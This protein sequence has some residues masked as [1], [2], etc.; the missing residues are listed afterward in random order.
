M[1]EQSFGPDLP[2]TREMFVTVLGRL[3]EAGGVAAAGDPSGF[4]DAAADSY[5]ARYV[6]WASENDIVQGMGSDHFG[7]GAPVT[8]EQMIV[9]VYRYFLFQNLIK[10]AG[11]GELEGYQDTNNVS[12]WAADAFGWAVGQGLITGRSSDLLDPSGQSSRAEVAMF[13]LR[14]FNMIYEDTI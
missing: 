6:A 5:Y 10:D 2:M 4:G 12:P 7:V 3:H 9:F 8:R 13:I 11:A 14:C 1:S